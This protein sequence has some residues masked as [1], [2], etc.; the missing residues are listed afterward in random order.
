ME[1]YLGRRGSLFRSILAHISHSN[2]PPLEP[3]LEKAINQ[4]F[5]YATWRDTKAAILMFSRNKD[6]KAVHSQI[7]GVVEG[8]KAYKEILPSSGSDTEFRF[9]L[10]HPADPEYELMLAVLAFNVP[11][12]ST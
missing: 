9:R 2:K 4:L 8:H 7:P 11:T 1:A 3:S 10:R 5:D 12:E 6:F